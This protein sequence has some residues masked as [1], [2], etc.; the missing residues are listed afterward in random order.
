MDYC[1]DV[2]LGWQARFLTKN[3]LNK[4]NGKVG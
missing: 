2:D 3:L 1:F 4:T